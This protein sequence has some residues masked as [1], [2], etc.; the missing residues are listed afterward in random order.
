MVLGPLGRN[1]QGQNN[2]HH[3]H[4]SLRTNDSQGELLTAMSAFM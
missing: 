3:S 4:E 2:G 1:H